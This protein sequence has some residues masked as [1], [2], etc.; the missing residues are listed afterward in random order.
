MTK[1]MRL[2]PY[3][4]SVTKAAAP[5][6]NWRIHRFFLWYTWFG[7]VEDVKDVVDDAAYRSFQLELSWRSLWGG[8]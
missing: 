1:Q 8:M 5:T 2:M 4:P 7:F 6:L 3:V